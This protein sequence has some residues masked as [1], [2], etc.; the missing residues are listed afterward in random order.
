MQRTRF[1]LAGVVAV[2]LVALSVSA[3]GPPAGAD[4]TVVAEAGADGTPATPPARADEPRPSATT[5]HAPLPD[6]TNAA[7]TKH[8]DPCGVDNDERDSIERANGF[9]ERPIDRVVAAAKEVFG[10]RYLGAYIAN[11]EQQYGVGIGLYQLTSADEDAFFEA[12]CFRRGD[13]VFEAGQ[14]SGTQMAAWRAAAVKI[15]S[16][17]DTGGCALDPDWRTGTITA[18]IKEGHPELR[19]KLERAIPADNLVIKESTCPVTW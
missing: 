13:V 5:S 19:E 12:T 9:S 15:T 16:G 14:V 8:P 10:G 18:L 2:G 7:S 3:C 4:G 17:K 1:R 6:R 11:V